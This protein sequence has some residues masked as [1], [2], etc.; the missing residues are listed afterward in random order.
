MIFDFV[1]SCSCSSANTE[2]VTIRQVGIK[3]QST[4]N[5]PKMLNEIRSSKCQTIFEY[6]EWILI[7]GWTVSHFYKF[8]QRWKWTDWWSSSEQKYVYSKV[9]MICFWWFQIKCSMIIVDSYILVTKRMIVER[10]IIRILRTRKKLS[11]KP[12]P[13]DSLYTVKTYL[14]SIVRKSYREL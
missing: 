8:L 6:K 13:L 3:S 12:F 7:R 9:E 10:W 2:A 11:H 14:F 1:F 4:Y 5:Y